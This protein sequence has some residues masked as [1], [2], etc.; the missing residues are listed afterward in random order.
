MNFLSH[1]IRIFTGFF[2]SISSTAV[3]TGS[4][5]TSLE[6]LS[7]VGEGNVLSGTTTITTASALVASFNDAYAYDADTTIAYV[8][9]LNQKETEELIKEL[10]IYQKEQNIEQPKMLV[11][12]IN[13]YKN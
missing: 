7:N 12:R 1:F 4:T 5:L 9:S 2:G 6:G 10:E 11:K 8:E 13:N 3:D